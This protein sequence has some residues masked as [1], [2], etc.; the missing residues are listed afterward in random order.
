MDDEQLISEVR[1]HP[2]LYNTQCGDVKVLLKKKNA[3]KLVSTG[4]DVPG[5]L[6]V[7]IIIGRGGY[8]G[9]YLGA[10]EPPLWKNTLQAKQ[11][12]I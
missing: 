4:T 2:C 3:W 9:G 7:L 12:R 6:F 1:E 11:G 10:E 5:K 8:R